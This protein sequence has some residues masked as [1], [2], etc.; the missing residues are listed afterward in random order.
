TVIDREEDGYYVGRTEADSP[1]VDGE[2]LIEKKVPL[3]VGQFYDIRI[4]GAD[5]YDLTGEPVC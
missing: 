1:E 4:T 2:V 5:E 3:E